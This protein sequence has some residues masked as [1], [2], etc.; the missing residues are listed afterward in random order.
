VEPLKLRILNRFGASEPLRAPDEIEVYFPYESSDALCK[1]MSFGHVKILNDSKG[2]FSVELSQFEVQGLL[3]GEKQNIT[4]QIRNG[5]TKR[6][7]VF[8]KVLNVAIMDVDGTQRKVI[9]RD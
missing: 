6:V 7:A 9:K 8:S 4:V 5:A 2:E 1:R 3:V